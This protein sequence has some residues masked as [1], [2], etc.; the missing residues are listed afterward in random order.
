MK[1]QDSAPKEL[2]KRGRKYLGI[3][4]TTIAFRVR[5]AD[6]EAIKEKIQQLIKQH[7]DTASTPS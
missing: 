2:R 4:T 5:V 1:Q 6:R 3:P 7:Y